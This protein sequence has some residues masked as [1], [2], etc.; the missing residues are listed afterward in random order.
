MRARSTSSGFCRWSVAE[1]SKPFCQ[2][3]QE[4]QEFSI[5]D[6]RNYWLAAATADSSQR[7][8]PPPGLIEAFWTAAGLPDQRWPTSPPRISGMGELVRD[9]YRAREASGKPNHYLNHDP[10]VHLAHSAG[11]LTD[12]L[13]I[14]M[15]L[16][17]QYLWCHKCLVGWDRETFLRY[18]YQGHEPEA[19]TVEAFKLHHDSTLADQVN[20][21]IAIAAATLDPRLHQMLAKIDHSGEERL[22]LACQHI[23]QQQVPSLTRAIAE[24]PL[25]HEA[26]AKMAASE[27]TVEDAAGLQ[28][29]LEG[30]S[31]HTLLLVEE[32]AASARPL[33][34][35][36]LDPR[37]GCSKLL[38]LRDA[39]RGVIIDR[40]AVM[41]QLE[42]VSGE[43]NSHEFNRMIGAV[44]SE[45]FGWF[46]AT[47]G[48]S[49]PEAMILDAL[50]GRNRKKLEDSIK[51]HAQMAPK[52]Y[53]LLPLPEEPKARDAE[54]RARYLKIEEFLQGSKK[55]G[56]ERQANNHVCAEVAQTN[57][58]L[59]AGYDDA[60]ELFFEI[61]S[62]LAAEAADARFTS[63]EYEVSLSYSVEGP[64]LVIVKDGKALKAVP[65]ALKKTK[66]YQELHDLYEALRTQ[67]RRFR[68]ALEKRMAL[69]SPI[70]PKQLASMW[71]APILREMLAKLVMIDEHDHT[72]LLDDSGTALIAVTG[73]KHILSDEKLWIG[74]PVVLER[75]GVLPAWR[76]HC[77]DKEIVQPLRQIFR[78][79]YALAPAEIVS[80]SESHRFVG[81]LL[82]TGPL[83]GLMKTRGWNSAG[84]DFPQPRKSF[85]ALGLKAF[86][87]VNDCGHYLTETQTVTSGV[88]YFEDTTGQRLP[89]ETI[90]ETV[91]SEV[92]RDVDLF[93]SV[94][95]T[96]G[97][98]ESSKE[99]IA[100]RQ[101]LLTA[102]V[103]KLKLKGVSQEGGHAV[104]E[105]RRSIYYIHL[106]TGAVYLGKGR[107]LCI[108]PAESW[109]KPQKIFLP[110]F[111]DDD[112]RIA[113]IFSKILLLSQDDKITD[114]HIL[115]QIDQALS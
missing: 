18:R 88:V 67:A 108:V 90:P 100:Q 43:L 101:A 97:D 72:G 75:L 113:E 21:M 32:F 49:A 8:Q 51:R 38:R 44:P 28:A 2:M 77:F 98:H 42:P 69:A 114:P 109:K 95:Q 54:V 1:A 16:E 48:D 64:A 7:L 74:H 80:S 106:A 47:F 68:R 76:S 83:G 102:L 92:M 29:A 31:D 87:E 81:H 46:R 41:S 36:I 82:A 35:G 45:L 111:A 30:F 110:F 23:E 78:E 22:L 61:E 105:G 39:L 93:V 91:F 50:D 15:T 56:S 20:R 27:F 115:E 17:N 37:P 89:L 34:R 53:A 103:G 55:F 96:A 85:G 10:W 52:C 94:A 6:Y 11:V 84:F 57:L 4:N 99:L 104:I 25:Q 14:Q 19:G 60:D 86:F 66:G 24:H 73:E 33:I 58:A 70:E 3:N 65:P 9:F 12:E 71:R 40:S 62:K 59:N 5:E 63:G 79:F 112:K 107:H 26:L 13:W